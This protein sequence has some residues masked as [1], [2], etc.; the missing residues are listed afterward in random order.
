M[1]LGNRMGSTRDWLFAADR[2]LFHLFGQFLLEVA[3]AFARAG[4]LIR[5]VLSKTLGG[6]AR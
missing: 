2:R 3:Q 1:H 6:S 5:D 4:R